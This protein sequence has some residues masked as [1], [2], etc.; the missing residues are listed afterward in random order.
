[1]GKNNQEKTDREL[2]NGKAACDN[3]DWNNEMRNKWLKAY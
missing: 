3:E 2:K 1:M